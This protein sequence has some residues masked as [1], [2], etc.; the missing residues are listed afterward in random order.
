M[1]HALRTPAELVARREKP[2]IFV[3]CE[4]YHADD[5]DTADLD[6]LFSNQRR[7]VEI[8]DG[9]PLSFFCGD[10]SRHVVLKAKELSVARPHGHITGSGPGFSPDAP[11]MSCACYAAGIFM[12]QLTMGNTSLAKLLSGVRDPLNIIRS[13]GLRVFVR[14]KESEPWQLLGVR[15]H[16]TCDWI[17]ARGIISKAPTCWRSRTRIGGRSRVHIWCSC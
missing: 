7:H 13:S 10:D 12:S 16:L 11:I 4:L 2:S 5:F 9:Q 15:R 1:L 8:V 6:R 17:A 14:R 3:R